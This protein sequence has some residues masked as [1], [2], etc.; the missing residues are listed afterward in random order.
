MNVEYQKAIEFTKK[1]YENFPVVSLFVPAQ[2]RKH[3]AIIYQFARTADDTADDV[4]IPAEKR[5]AA[6]KELEVN[7]IKALT[8]DYKTPFWRAFHNTIMTYELSAE[9]FFR[10]LSAF[11]FDVENRGFETFDEILNYCEK[12]ANPVGRVILELYDI[13]ETEA[14]NYSDKI[15]TALQLANFYQDISRDLPNGRIYLPREEL[16]K[17]GISEKEITSPVFNDA[18]RALIKFSVERNERLFREGEALFP[19]L[20]F[21]LKQQIRI[22]VAAGLKILDKIKML[23][24]NTID[25]RPEIT[26][27]EVLSLVFNSV[28]NADI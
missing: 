28:I 23:D 4:A 12:S 18:F 11:K 8:G 6:L 9:Y 2:L 15:C 3:I 13:R 14:M 7:L 24:Y 10:L 26:K 20:P 5:L 25:F 1:H 19:F 27:F 22:T 17:F 16:R 21:P